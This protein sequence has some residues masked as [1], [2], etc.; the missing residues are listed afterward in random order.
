MA[1]TCPDVALQWHRQCEERTPAQHSGYQLTL[2]HSSMGPH[3]RMMLHV[4][5]SSWWNM[6]R[7]RRPIEMRWWRMRL[8]RRRAVRMWG[9][10]IGTLGRWGGCRRLRRRSHWTGCLWWRHRTTLWRGTR[11][12][13]QFFLD[14]PIDL[15]GK[16]SSENSLTNKTQDG[17]VFCL[18]TEAHFYAYI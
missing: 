8:R 17:F 10:L 15:C 4:G 9:M 13:P 5:R 2:R 6:V 16:S 7:G 18:S 11:H 3:S 14:F 1:S 12:F